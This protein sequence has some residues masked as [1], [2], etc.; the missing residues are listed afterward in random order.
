MILLVPIAEVEKAILETLGQSL[1]QVFG[2]RIEI[3]DRVLLPQSGDP[4]RG[5]YRAYALLALV[6]SPASGNRALGV[7]DVDLYAPGLNF[8]FGQDT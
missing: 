8:V 6:P 2:S 1:A 5:Q 7:V 3:G 4:R